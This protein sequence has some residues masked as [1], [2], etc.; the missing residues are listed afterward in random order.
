MMEAVR[1]NEQSPEAYGGQSGPPAVRPSNEPA[2]ADPELRRQF[3]QFQQ[4]QQFQRFQEHQKEQGGQA[5]PPVPWA[6]Q[7]PAKRPVWQRALRTKAFRKLVLLLL[8]LIGL[9]WAYQSIF[10]DN[11]ETLPASQTG[12]QSYENRK[13]LQTVPDQSVR[14]VYQ[15]VGDGD[16]GIACGQFD[17]NAARQFAATVGASNCEQ[18]VA[19]LHPQVTS[20]RDYAEPVFPRQYRN[21]TSDV[22]TIEISSCELEIVGGPK[23]GR[24]T[25]QR[26]EFQGQWIITGYRTETCPTTR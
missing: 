25:V 7:P 6:P 4:F 21:L 10:N 26:T 23:L 11:D 22:T 14:M 3:E 17:E 19:K 16:A 24:F 18:A 2:P 9:Y 12:G 13:L 1:E 15:R 5:P 20:K 8:V